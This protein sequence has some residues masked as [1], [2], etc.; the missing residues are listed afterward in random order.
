MSNVWE[1]TLSEGIKKISEGSLTTAEWTEALLGRIDV[2]EEKIHAWTTLDSKGAL[3][4][5]R[6]IDTGQSKPG[7]LTGAPIGVKDIINVKGLPCEANS[8][9]L[10]GMI[11]GED[12]HCVAR[13]REAGAVILGKTVTTQFATGDPSETRNP[14]N[15]AHSPGGS[16]SGSAAAVATG[17]IPAALGSQTGGSVLRPSAYCGVIGFKPSYGLISRAGVVEV[18]WTFDH[19][20]TLT[21]SV[22]DAALLLAHM[23]GPDD[24]DETT[25]GFE[26]LRFGLNTPNKPQKACYPKRGV[27]KYASAEVSDW[28]DR[29]VEKLRGS[30]VEIVEIEYPVDFQ[31]LHDTHR[32][33]MN[34]DGAAYHEKMFSENADKYR[35]VIRTLVENGLKT[36]ALEYARGLRRRSRLMRD[37]DKVLSEFDFIILPS[38]QEAPALAEESTGSAFFNEPATQSGLPAITLPL[39]RGDKNLPFGI[40]FIGRKLGDITLLASAAWCE[41]EL[42]WGVEI[43]DT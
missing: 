38:F 6:H 12:A 34:V 4:S 30:G 20:G 11:P 5:A 37:M 18:S 14:W 33:I 2:C 31:I 26:P 28:I 15:L 7:P 22:E 16:S 21:R 3:E 8:P 42:G 9:I 13:L 40:Q 35:P 29:G 32:M 19:I 25:Q 10:K 23:A 39:G 1:L 24:A 27:H 43:A 41:A 36:S 17:M